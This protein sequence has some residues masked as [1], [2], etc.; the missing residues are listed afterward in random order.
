MKVYREKFG[1]VKVYREKL[2][3]TTDICATDTN[4]TELLDV[5]KSISVSAGIRTDYVLIMNEFPVDQSNVKKA[6]KN[7]V[8]SGFLTLFRIPSATEVYIDQME[9]HL[10]SV[11]YNSESLSCWRLFGVHFTSVPSGFDEYT[12]IGE[13]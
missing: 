10:F 9:V 5:I 7:I 11:L 2:G 4:K 8:K 1:Y 13:V 12:F 6:G 3:Y